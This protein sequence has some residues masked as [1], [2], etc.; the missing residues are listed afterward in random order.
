MAKFAVFF[1]FRPEAV[2][3]MMAKPSDRGEVVRKLCESAG[4]TMEAYYMM[5]GD[6]D[7]FVV[8][9]GADSKSA[10]SVSLAVSSSGAFSSISTHELLTT[11]EFVEAL[12]AASG[13]TYT[14][15]GG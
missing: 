15:P 11:A 14:A 8:V 13:L 1:K 12:Q 7:G 2:K 5:F 9:D 3:A 4:A 10:A 6:W